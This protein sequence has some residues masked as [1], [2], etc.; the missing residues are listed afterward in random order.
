MTVVVRAPLRIGFSGGGTDIMPYAG[1]HG[2]CVVSATID[3]HA[4]A[5]IES[6]TEPD[7][8]LLFST[9][10]RLLDLPYEPGYA[11]RATAGDLIG[12][13]LGS[14]SA[15]AVAVITALSESH[16]RPLSRADLAMFAYRLERE[17]LGQIGGAQDHHSAAH[18]GLNFMEFG[19]HGTVAVTPLRLEP[20]PLCDSGVR[21]DSGQ[22]LKEQVRAVQRGERTVLHA[23]YRMK[24][25]A[26]EM[27]HQLVKR[28]LK[29]FA[30]LMALAWEEKRRLAGV[31]QPQIRPLL[32]TGQEAG[33]AAAKVRGAGG[34]GF[35]L[36][37]VAPARRSEVAS[38]LAAAGGKPRAVTLVNDGAGTRSALRSKV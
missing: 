5:T 30:E 8:S 4:Q 21:R 17:E 32:D 26:V 7:G 22:V 33:S 12:S 1:E 10:R 14:S 24:T 37:F 23:L 9:A 3:L 28:D 31:E 2:G 11:G 20:E 35:L 13:G 19:A 38:A 36:F 15:S 18:G 25:F 27:R 16:G 34:G 29:S 6:S